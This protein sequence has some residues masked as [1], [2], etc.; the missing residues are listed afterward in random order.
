MFSHDLEKVY[1]SRKWPEEAK[2]YL[3]L[4]P[5]LR[6]WLDPEAVFQGKRVLDI[7]AGECTYTRLIAERFGP[8]EIVACELF[9]ERMLPA[10]RAN[11]SSN[12][13]FIAGDAFLLPFHDGC[14]D[15][16]WGSGVLSQIPNLQDALFEIRRV[17]EGGG[18]YAGWEPNPFNAAIAYRYLFKPHSSNQYLFWPWWIRSQL[19]KT[20][21]DVKIRYFYAKLPRMRN[22][23]MGTCMGIVAHLAD[24]QK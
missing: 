5:Y 4:E 15:V 9:R 2:P 10:A 14:F 22:R 18:L 17:L 16:V 3:H 20:G 1:Y 13:K 24:G 7:G 11:R 12:L 6:C 21:F 23:F 19:K 8:K